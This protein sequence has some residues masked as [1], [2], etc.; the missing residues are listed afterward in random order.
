MYLRGNC[1]WVPPLLSIKLKYPDLF[2]TF[3]SASFHFMLFLCKVYSLICF[4]AFKR[5]KLR[6]N[7]VFTTTATCICFASL[8]LIQI[9]HHLADFAR[10]KNAHAPFHFPDACL[11]GHPFYFDYKD[12]ISLASEF[13]FQRFNAGKLWK[14]IRICCNWLKSHN[15]P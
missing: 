4:Y 15:T 6:W 1:R 12:F 9:T 13:S 3:R 7:V 11:F 5:K 14:V 2:T 8:T 10:D